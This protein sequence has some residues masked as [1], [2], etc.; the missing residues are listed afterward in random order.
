MRPKRY[1]TLANQAPIVFNL[2]PGQNGLKHF[3]LLVDY[4]LLYRN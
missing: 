3:K 2:V 4:M 1:I